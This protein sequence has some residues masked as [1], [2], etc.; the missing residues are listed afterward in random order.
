MNPAQRLETFRHLRVVVVGDLMLD[1]YL[2][3]RADRVSPEAPVPIVTVQQ[4][5]SVA[6]GAANVAANIVAAGSSCRLFGAIGA[7]AAGVELTAILES[8]GIAGSD[9]LILPDRVTTTKTRV[10]ARGQQ[11]LRVDEEDSGDLEPALLNRLAESVTAALANADVLILEDYDKGTLAPTLIRS[12]IEA[13]TR[14]R[15]PVIVDPKLRHFFDYA[16]ATV[17][18]PNRRELLAALGAGSDT[19][20]LLAVARARLGVQNLLL[21]LGAEGMILVD[22]SDRVEA[23]PARAREVFDISGA[24]DTVTAWVAL[25]LASGASVL[26]AAHLATVAAGVEVGKSGVSVVHPQEVLAAL[27]PPD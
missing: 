18:K 16:A 7:D 8:L 5:R 11:L 2:V 27:P 22:E 26:E 9:L 14:R 21:T 13:A 1:R 23:V 12:T 6:G 10:V 19:P 20:S 25:A 3:G 15:I 4:R 24:G 17:F